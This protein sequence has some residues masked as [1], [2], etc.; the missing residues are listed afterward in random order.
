MNGRKTYT[1]A[2]AAVLGGVA[3]YLDGALDL[4]Q[5]LDAIWAG[6]VAAAL[7][8]GLANAGLK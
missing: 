7:R 6:G 1:L 5:A 3:G 8:H 2:L 4:K